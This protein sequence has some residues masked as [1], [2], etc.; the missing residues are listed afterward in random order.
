MKPRLRAET[1]RMEALS[2]SR[3][4]EMLALMQRIYADVD[5]DAFWRDLAAKQWIILLLD[6]EIGQVAGFST[7]GLE[8]VTFGGSP[9]ELLFSGDT[10]ID[11]AYWGQKVLDTAFAA[12]LVRRKLRRPWRPFFWLLLSA[13]FKT[14][15]IIL[16][17]FPGAF[18]RHDR[19]PDPEEAAFLDAYCRRRWGSAYDPEQ[20]I[21]RLPGHY[22]V[23]EGVAPI[24]EAELRRPNIAFFAEKNPGHLNGDELVCL[25]RV[26]LRDLLQAFLRIA[27]KRPRT[28]IPERPGQ[29]A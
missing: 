5:V 8:E 18:P 3:R 24:T 7:I 28:R 22:R 12:F 13:G 20:G 2:P 11:P 19:D 17:Y 6:R 27:R 9:A 4:E 25:A 21:V 14:Y 10:V 23:R 26:R 29:G 16:N 1:L 15:L